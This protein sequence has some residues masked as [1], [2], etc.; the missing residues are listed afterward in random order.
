[1]LVDENV[2]DS[3]AFVPLHPE[4][5]WIV[6]ESPTRQPTREDKRR[7]N[8]VKKQPAKV[9]SMQ[10]HRNKL[11]HENR[12]KI[13]KIKNAYMSAM[14]HAGYEP[15]RTKKGGINTR[16]HNMMKAIAGHLYDALDEIAETKRRGN[17]ADVVSLAAWKATRKRA[18]LEAKLVDAFSRIARRIQHVEPET[19]EA[20]A[21]LKFAAKTLIDGHEKGWFQ[22][23]S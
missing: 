18:A 20:Q 21:A 15:L 17:P 23:P 6:K 7:R 1:M 8:P 13:N 3:P 14:Y 10:D 2:V 16:S 4:Q 9:L 11:A 5:I 22:G 12:L 19:S